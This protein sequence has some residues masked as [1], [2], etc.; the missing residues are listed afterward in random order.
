MNDDAIPESEHE[1]Q[2]PAAEFLTGGDGFVIPPPAPKPAPPKPTVLVPGLHITDTGASV[3]QSGDDFATTAIRALP[4]DSIYRY[5]SI[6]GEF[7]GDPGH[8]TFV[9]L[10]RSSIRLLVDRYVRP[11]RWV[12][13]TKTSKKEEDRHVPLYQPCTADNGTLLMS[14]ARTASQIPEIT[15]ISRHP[16]VIR[17][18]NGTC[19]FCPPG[20]AHGHYY[21]EPPELGGILDSI[22]THQNND[23]YHALV[24][25]FH[26][27]LDD[28]LIDFPFETDADKHN[29]I[30]LFLTPILR[31][32]IRGP[33]P[34][35]VVTAP[36]E[37][38]G[39]TY[40][41]DVA[42]GG[43]LLGESIP[44]S[45]LG[46]KEEEREKRILGF[47]LSA[48]NIIHLDNVSDFV[49]SPVLCSLLT[50]TLFQSRL[51]GGNKVPH[52]PNRTTVVAS[53]NAFRA[54]REISRRC[55]PIRLIPPQENL[56]DR[57]YHHEDFPVF[58]LEN[59]STFLSCLL[60]MVAMRLRHD[61]DIDS[62]R[63]PNERGSFVSWS[64]AV[65]SVLRVARFDK[66]L[67][68]AQEWLDDTDD[69]GR[70]AHALIDLWWQRYQTDKVTAGQVYQLAIDLGLYQRAFGYAKS[71]KSGQTTFSTNILRKLVGQVFGDLRVCS[72]PSGSN[73]GYW[74]TSIRPPF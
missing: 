39:K 2:V 53:G 44:A 21:D 63:V 20:F 10:D 5:G 11:I 12:K 24:K 56:N 41:A 69:E 55:V 67:T 58:V 49:D 9:E 43:I 64:R 30:G 16:V 57:K 59:R 18:P 4:P 14:A 35:H 45:S 15:S 62:D 52:L 48:Q 31:P 1:I 32:A 8:R 7:V 23:E 60:S 13:A 28:L 27:I 74:L 34:M 25:D 6:I 37:G 3:E 47:L 68:N 19:D 70:D 71:E 26:R 72:K 33:V 29:A 73:T 61:Q 36:K 46:A 66:H 17:L 40:L 50:S 65:S 38:T 54:T 51:L 22:Q 42:M